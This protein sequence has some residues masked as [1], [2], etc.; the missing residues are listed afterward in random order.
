MEVTTMKHYN[1]VYVGMDTHKDKFSLCCY[2]FE[3][4]RTAYEQNIAADYR[5]VLKYLDAMRRHYGEDAEFICGYEAG[6]LGYT[7]YRDLTAHNVKC[8]ILAPSTM[9]KVP[10]KKYIKTD[11]RDAANIARCLA[12]RTYNEVHVPTIEDEEVKEFIRM[13]DDHKQAL[14]R[15]KQQIL[16]FCLRQG[17]RYTDG[18]NWTQKH[19]KWLKALKFVGVYRELLDEYLLTYDKLSETVARMD[20][21]IAELADGER[22]REPVKK[23]RCFI[24]IETH[25]ALSLVAEISDFNRFPSAERFT[26]FLGLVPGEHTSSD[27]HH[28]LG[29]TKA[30]NSHLRRL[31]TESAH[32]FG[33]GKIGY[34]SQKLRKRQEGNPPEV[35]QYADKA[36]ERLRRKF[37][38]M[39]FAGKKYSVASIAIARELACFV[40]GM[41]TNHIITTA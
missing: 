2:T 37:Y 12:H 25:T 38:K 5:L 15:I 4:D 36:N 30:G 35:V 13:R 40:W 1:T 6:C 26:S 24:G 3:D 39:T 17:V 33:R 11:K 18:D 27:S 22:Y 19:M 16:A 14:K 23:L 31:L 20:R 34:K 29:I 8:I 32:S 10:G 7:L 9:P 21:R 41:M 28:Q